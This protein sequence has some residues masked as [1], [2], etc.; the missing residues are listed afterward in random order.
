MWLRD[1][2]AEEYMRVGVVVTFL[3][4]DRRPVEP[5]P[6]LPEG[7]VIRKLPVCSVAQYRALY[8]G[9]G[10]PW[11]WWLR[12]VMPDRELAAHLSRPAI[13]IYLAEM[14]G[15]V[16]G[17]YELDSGHWPAINL[18]YFGLMPQ[19]IGR[20]FGYAFLRRA[21]DDCWA[22][23]GHAVTVNTCTA[24]HPR[25]LANYRRAGFREVRSV[26]EVWDIPRKLGL[27]KPAHMNP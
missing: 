13:N 7:L 6:P 8:N 24:D 3:R 20:G 23:G 25:A 5:A 2:D 26:E 21:V 16:V 11:L 1:P 4:M 12:R 15:E 9:V 18:S 14:A 17:F 10:A 27:V 19:A 22:M